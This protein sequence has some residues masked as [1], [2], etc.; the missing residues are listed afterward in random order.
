VEKVA[1][2]HCGESHDISVME[3]SM[4]RPEPLLSVP[5]D[6]RGTATYESK[7]VCILFAETPKSLFARLTAR[8]QSHRYFLRVL[9]PFEV[10]GRDLPLS[11]GLWVEVSERQYERV[12]DLWDDPQQHREPPFEAVLANNLWDYPPAEGLPGLVH[13]QG[14]DSIPKFFL[15]AGS[16]PL[17]V[18]QHHGVTEARVLEWLDPILHQA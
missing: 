17:V 7:N 1:C 16:H 4:K 14:P 10:E 5:E 13:L 3:P 2:A 8:P 11:W 15:S 6:E 12:M 18:E 9:L